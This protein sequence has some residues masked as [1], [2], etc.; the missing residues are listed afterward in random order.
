MSVF[1]MLACQEKGRSQFTG[2]L[3]AA[4]LKSWHAELL[5]ELNPEQIFFAYDSPGDRD[6][7]FEAGALLAEYEMRGNKLRCYVLIG[8]PGDTLEKAESRL[9]ETIDAGFLP[10]AMLYK[11]DSGSSEKQWRRFQ[12]EWARPAIIKAKQKARV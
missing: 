4:L 9:F 3:E 12:K 8:Y 10:M 7:L 11:D 5:A 2:G 1:A 6:P